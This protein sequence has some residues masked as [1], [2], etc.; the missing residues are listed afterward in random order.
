MANKILTDEAE[1]LDNVTKA[2]A[3]TKEIYDYVSDECFERMKKYMTQESIIKA[4]ELRNKIL[5]NSD[6][7]Q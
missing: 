4:I 6:G 5:L 1:F 7:K 2:F 3:D